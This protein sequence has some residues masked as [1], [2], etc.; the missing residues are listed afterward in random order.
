MKSITLTDQGVEITV[1]VLTK[2]EIAVIQA[3]P[4]K[5][6]RSQW[7]WFDVTRPAFWIA[8]ADRILR[9]KGDGPLSTPQRVPTKANKDTKALKDD[10]VCVW[11]PHPDVAEIL[12]L[13]KPKGAKGEKI[14]ALVVENG[15]DLS[16]FPIVDKTRISVTPI[17]DM[18]YLPNKLDE[19]LAANDGSPVP[20]ATI[21]ATDLDVLV[22]LADVGTGPLCSVK[23]AAGRG[24]TPVLWSCDRADVHWTYGMMDHRG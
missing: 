14:P 19:V 8:A 22:K 23:L 4:D 24:N 20:H 11:F 1:I 17:T 16:S 5:N 2:A 12:V 13:R 10:L 3:V 21:T 9:A 7:A 6:P 15:M 18:D